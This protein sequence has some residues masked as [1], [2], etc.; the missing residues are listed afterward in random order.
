ML[1]VLMLRSGNILAGPISAGLLKRSVG[2]GML[3]LGYRSEYTPLIVFTGITTLLG[4]ISVL[5]RLKT[6]FL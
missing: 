4:G 3:S 5:G 2:T 6:G 1:F